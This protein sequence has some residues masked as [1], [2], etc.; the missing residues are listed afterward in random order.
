MTYIVV[1]TGVLS[2]VFFSLHENQLGDLA[3][4]RIFGEI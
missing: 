3:F 1:M 4:L 2:P